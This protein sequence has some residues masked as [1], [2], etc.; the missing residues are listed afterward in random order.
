MH[1]SVDVG[2][3]HDI[4]SM[5]WVHTHTHSLSWKHSF[6]NKTSNISSTAI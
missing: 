1:A 3:E 5:L 6:I 4:P 2:V